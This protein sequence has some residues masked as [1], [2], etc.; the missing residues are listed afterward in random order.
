MKF[1][2]LFV[3]LISLNQE[4][5]SFDVIDGI[6]NNIGTFSKYKNSETLIELN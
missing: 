1:I 3:V 6:F 2:C 5:S 4:A